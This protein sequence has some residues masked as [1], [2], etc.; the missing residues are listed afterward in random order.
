MKAFATFEKYKLYL[1]D[2][3]LG[4][5]KERALALT[6][7]LQKIPK[8]STALFFS[9]LKSIQLKSERVWELLTQACS[10]TSFYPT[11]PS[12]QERLRP[13]SQ[14]PGWAANHHQQQQLL[15][16]TKIPTE[17]FFLFQHT[18]R[19]IHKCSLPLSQTQQFNTLSFPSAL[20]TLFLV[21]LFIQSSWSLQI[22]R[23]QLVSSHLT[24]SELVPQPRK[25][26]QHCQLSRTLP[27][28]AIGASL[29]E[30]TVQVLIWGE[31]LAMV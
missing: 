22:N 11:G 24:P 16:Q 5:P 17:L 27:G 2:N 10:V 25:G 19:L 30:K 6:S 21:C 1:S 8:T 15:K 31:K 23:A 12:F 18:K 26:K 14:Y 9:F 28:L 20:A 4:Q 13:K 29:L 3:L 7:G